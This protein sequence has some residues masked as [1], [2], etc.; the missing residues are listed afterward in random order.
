MDKEE[1]PLGL[2]FGMATNI[3]ATVA[4][5]N[6]SDQERERVVEEARNVNSKAEMEQLVNRIGRGGIG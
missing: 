4:F 1:M 6:M 5:A 3:K 2:S